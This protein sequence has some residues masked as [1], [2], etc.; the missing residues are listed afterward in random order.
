MAEKTP[1][2]RAFQLVGEPTSEPGISDAPMSFSAFV[3]SLTTSGLLHL[4]VSPGGDFDLPE[5]AEPKIDLA[6]GRETIAIL[7]L[8]RT[9]TRGNLDAEEAALL[10][11]AIHDLK[12]RF[13]EVKRQQASG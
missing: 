2:D 13:V 11:R 12:M 9:K 3:L 8:L 10:S 6:M 7:E 1:Q 5:L 4:G